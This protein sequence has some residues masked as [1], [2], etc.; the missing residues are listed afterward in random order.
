VLEWEELFIVHGEELVCRYFVKLGANVLWEDGDFCSL[1]GTSDGIRGVSRPN[2]CVVKSGAK[3]GCTLVGVCGDCN[4]D[5]IGSRASNW[6]Q[7]V[8]C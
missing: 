1:G 3:L 7:V 5:R 2:S 6:R 8:W 4:G